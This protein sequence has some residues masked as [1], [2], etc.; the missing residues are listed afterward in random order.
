MVEGILPPQD[1]W[2][3]GDPIKQAEDRFVQMTLVAD[4]L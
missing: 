4:G 2:E 1:H 3:T